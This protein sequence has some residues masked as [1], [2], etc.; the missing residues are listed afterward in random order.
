MHLDFF[1]ATGLDSSLITAVLIGLY[2]RFFFTEAFGW[3]FSGLVV[4]GYLASV[5][6]VLPVSAAVT[7]CEAVVTLL[8][9]QGL[10]AVLSRAHLGT[11]VFGRDRFLWI[12]VMSVAVRLLFEGTLAE[13]LRRMVL[14]AW[15]V[16]PSEG[17]G[18]YGVGLVLVPLFANAC[19]KPGLTRGLGQNLVVTALTYVALR[20]LLSF[21]NL[22]LGS[23]QLS[24]ERIAL[25][26]AASPKAYLLIAAGALL[27]SRA[28]LRF[29]WDTSGV[30]I[31]GLLCLGWFVPERALLT[32]FEASLLA[33]LAVLFLRLPGPRAWNV[34][35]PR[36]IVLVF[37]LGYALQFVLLHLLPNLP[38]MHDLRGVGYL[39]SSLLAVKIWQ[40]KNPAL[41]VVP[42]L[43][44]SL[45]GLVS[46]SLL[47]YG[48]SS[49]FAA[50]EDDAP[51]Q[52]V[53]E[54]EAASECAAASTLRHELWTSRA[55]VA[56]SGPSKAA[57][58]IAN[59]ELGRFG[60]LVHALDEAKRAPCGELPALRAAAA[61]LGLSL[62]DVSDDSAGEFLVLREQAAVA[63][64]LRGFG[65]VLIA[66]APASRTAL[67]VDDT[68]ANGVD[69]DVLLA[70]ARRL[71]P[72]A[73]LVNGLDRGQLR[74]DAQHER[75]TPLRSAA[76]ALSVVPLAVRATRE[77]SAALSRL[78]PEELTAAL[79]AELGPLA[80]TG[81]G[82]WSAELLLPEPA[83][84]RLLAGFA[85]Q[86]EEHA[87]SALWTRAGRGPESPGRASSAELE[88][89]LDEVLR[90]ALGAGEPKERADV[91]RAADAAGISHWEVM[92]PRASVFAF[93]ELPGDGGLAIWPGAAAAG[94]LV[95]T[96]SMAPGMPELAAR[97]ARQLGARTFL[98]D[99]LS[100]RARSH[101]D[102]TRAAIALSAALP[103]LLV[104]VAE[105]DD[106]PTTLYVA[107]AQAWHDELLAKLAAAGLAPVVRISVD[108]RTPARVQALFEHRS[109]APGATLV[110]SRTDRARFTPAGLAAVD[111]NLL[112]RVHI[113]VLE[114]S[115]EPH[116][117]AACA[118]GAHEHTA[119]WVEA[120]VADAQ[121][122]AAE[123]SAALL[124]GLSAHASRLG[125]TLEAVSDVES[126][127][128]FLIASR[129]G[130]TAAALLRDSDGVRRLACP[131]DAHAL[132]AA[133][134][135]RG[136]AVVIGGAP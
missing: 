127:D 136:A 18:F 16:D 23:L 91:E 106:R 28:N 125:V 90:P 19:W 41:V 96:L 40:K 51:P 110:V 70:L 57:P 98:V 35:G 22:T 45:L 31:P 39:L 62:A 99:G 103:K 63:R 15:G 126:G 87:L 47:G 115:I 120:F 14:T 37:S 54:G 128:A 33:L 66:R 50:L 21:T 80:R 64:A 6:V 5:A 82:A 112:A 92:Q 83:R 29:G 94:P 43:A 32:V 130:T 27:A 17:F 20:T 101:G 113:P 24:F 116:L 107:H 61:T 93:G 121:R 78:V 129:G 46:G 135:A 74:G 134:A 2:V 30:M 77:A 69:S 44:L 55:R 49:A 26:F 25:D 132:S 76:S 71:K 4:P 109:A 122:Y 102:A 60:Q 89:W 67:I 48:L 36:R 10:C 73:I 11:P 52:V 42:A 119:D 114:T 124:F 85:S 95:E 1:P 123:R 133:I 8:C 131:S 81:F 7:V 72:A 118:R 68:L 13:P 56:T 105:P 86:R 34:E 38:A 108:D 100:E 75:N 88:L 79:S 9:V 12:V 53:A 97:V 3:T 59:D 104:L 111:R 84:A 117:L 58:R 65:T